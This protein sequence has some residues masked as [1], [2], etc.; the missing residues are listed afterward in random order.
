VLAVASGGAHEARGRRVGHRHART[1][2][3]ADLLAI[4]IHPHPPAVEAPGAVVPLAV[5]HAPGVY[6]GI[7]LDVPTDIQP[8]REDGTI[9]LEREQQAPVAVLLAEDLS[10]PL[11]VRGHHPGRERDALKLAHPQAARDLQRMGPRELQRASV[12]SAHAHEAR[13]GCNVQLRLAG[14]IVGHR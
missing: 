6:R 1:L 8:H 14:D 12:H 5:H 9:I 11:Q 10:I 7:A 4:E 2:E 13:V 3:R